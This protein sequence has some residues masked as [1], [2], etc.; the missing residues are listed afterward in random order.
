M[1]AGE[2]VVRQGVG[3]AEGR[4]VDAVRRR[5]ASRADE[6]ARRP[7]SMD[8][9]TIE[10]ERLLLRPWRDSDYAPFADAFRQGA[11]DRRTGR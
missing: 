11:R 10:T 1:A 4:Q 7:L 9:V 5:R 2:R 6:G 3:P 8:P